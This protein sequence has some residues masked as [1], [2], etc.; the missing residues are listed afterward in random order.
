MSLYK[1]NSLYTSS[2]TRLALP[3]TCYSF[4]KPTQH[5]LD[6][7]SSL[8]QWDIKVF[9]GDVA[10]AYACWNQWAQQYL[11]LLS[12]V[13]FHS[14]GD[15]P[16]IKTGLLALPTSRELPT[17]HRPYIVLYNRTVSAISELYHTPSCVNTVR[18]RSY[19]SEILKTAQ[20]LLPSFQARGPPPGSPSYVSPLLV[21]ACKNNMI[22]NNV[23]KPLGDHGLQIPGHLTVKRFTSW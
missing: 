4:P 21:I 20:S 2:I 23:G 9:D 5:F 11:T 17:T 7:F 13:D 12:N 22:F 14:R 15:T 18:F 1:Y 8:F 16:C 10:Q 19:L 3:P 6:I